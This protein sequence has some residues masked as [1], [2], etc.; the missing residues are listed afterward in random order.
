MQINKANTTFKPTAEN[1]Q[2]ARKRHSINA[3]SRPINA[4]QTKQAFDERHSDRP[5]LG[6]IQ[7]PLTWLAHSVPA[8]LMCTH[9]YQLTL[10][11]AET[12]SHAVL[13][14]L[15]SA[16]SWISF[17]FHQDGCWS[18]RPSL[19]KL[20]SSV[21]LRQMKVALLLHSNFTATCNGFGLRLH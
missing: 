20:S 10:A 7:H 5:Y 15:A 18:R 6:R 11:S 13:A 3:Q 12:A 16:H 2:Q 8:L 17:F 1:W 14:E 4:Q 9:F 19:A 21:L